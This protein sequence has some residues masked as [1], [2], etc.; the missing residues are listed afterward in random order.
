MHEKKCMETDTNS[1]RTE[2][3][4]VSCNYPLSLPKKV[5][6]KSTF[7]NPFFV[8][9]ELDHPLSSSMGPGLGRIFLLTQVFPQIQRIHDGAE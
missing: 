4:P 5:N 8:D 9:K 7:E 1:Y 6:W 2:F 3:V